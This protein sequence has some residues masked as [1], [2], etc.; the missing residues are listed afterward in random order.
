MSAIRLEGVLPPR[1]GEWEAPLTLEVP[2]GAC[3]VIRTSVGRA[4]ALLRMCAGLEAPWAGRASVLGQ[5]LAE[6]PRAAARAT[7]RFLGVALRPDGLMSNLTLR[8][9]LVVPLVYTGLARRR[10]AEAIADDTLTTFGVGSWADERPHDVPLEIRERAVVARAAAR[11][12][13]LMLLED[14][15]TALPMDEAEWILDLSRSRTET[16]LI[17]TH[18]ADSPAH[19]LA[20]RA[21]VWDETGF[22]LAAQ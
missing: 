17:T 10:D 6:L 18:R 2:E 9:N 20:D 14:P 5:P 3:L 22:H 1:D 19:R 12:P 21:A 15:L 16:L 8:Q 4:T 7:R 13:R 11:K